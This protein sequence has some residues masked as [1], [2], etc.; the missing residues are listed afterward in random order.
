MPN[1]PT[2]WICPDDFYQNSDDDSVTFIYIN[3]DGESQLYADDNDATHADIL[4]KHLI[5][6][7]TSLNRDQDYPRKYLEDNFAL[8][9]RSGWYDGRCSKDDSK[10]ANNY[11]VIS[12]WNESNEIYDRLLG[13]FLEEFKQF[14]PNGAR[15]IISTPNGNREFSDTA[16]IVGARTK[17][18]PEYYALRK[19]LHL[20]RGDE[21]KRAME[22]LGLYNPEK[23]EHPMARSLKDRG[24]LIPG[25]K[26]WAPYSEELIINP[27]VG[28]FIGDLDESREW[29]MDRGQRE[30]VDGDAALVFFRQLLDR[31]VPARLGIVKFPVPRIV[32]R[33]GGGEFNVN[34]WLRSE[35]HSFD[36]AVRIVGAFDRLVLVSEDSEFDDLLND[37]PVSDDVD[38]FGDV[39]GAC[40]MTFDSDQVNSINFR[41]DF[42][43]RVFCERCCGEAMASPKYEMGHNSFHHCCKD[44]LERAEAGWPVP[45]P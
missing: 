3:I 12:F 34:K 36:D 30:F 20:L 22:K 23:A 32:V 40:G 44:C 5:G 18:D 2:E 29:G 8:L 37:E 43:G 27:M 1:S 15:V 41:C 38:E 45:L 6:F 4:V 14:V 39:C 17:V 42:C 13:G 24:L 25:G 21:K 10:S 9:G 19:D 7:W 33:F 31:S 11:Y 16:S 28:G 26:W 35:P